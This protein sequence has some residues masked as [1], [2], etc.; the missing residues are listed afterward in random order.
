LNIQEYIS[1]GIIESYVLGLASPEERL[2]FEKNCEAYAEIRA[3][4]ENFEKALE[5]QAMENAHTPPSRLKGKV[6]AQIDIE[7]EERLMEKGPRREK[8]PVAQ[9]RPIWSRYVAAVAVI[10]LVVSTL[11]NFYFFTKYKEYI[12]KYD[13]LVTA[14]TQTALQNQSMQTRLKDYESALNHIRNPGMAIVKMPAMPTSP[15]SASMA[16]VYWDTK[17]KDVYLMVNNLP[18]P[19]IDKQYQLWAIVDGKPVDAG[20]FEMADNSPIL[21]MKNIPQAQAF[22]I[23]LERK[24]GSPTP[25]MEAMY[26]MGKVTG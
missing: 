20:V 7:K 16:T 18:M 8:F 17:S 2:E 21:K 24:G 10:L 9:I 13:N 5:E 12:A 15:S 14:Q 3:A 11:L 6:F 25:T 19:A 22:A 1:S 26:V 23:T 4:R